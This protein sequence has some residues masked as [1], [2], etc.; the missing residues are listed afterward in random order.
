[1]LETLKS[2]NMKFCYLLSKIFLE[3]CTEILREIGNI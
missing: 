2:F 3:N 1:M